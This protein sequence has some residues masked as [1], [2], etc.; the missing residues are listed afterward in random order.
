VSRRHP[1]PTSA[2]PFFRDIVGPPHSVVTAHLVDE[3]GHPALRARDE[4]VA[5][6]VQALRPET[7]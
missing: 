5:Y 3:P 1:W 4:F 6:F 7:T 2:P